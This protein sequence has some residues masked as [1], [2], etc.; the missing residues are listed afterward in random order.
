M[1]MYMQVLVHVH[2]YK[3]EKNYIHVLK[4]SFYTHS[5]NE[6]GKATESDHHGRKLTPSA[7]CCTVATT[8]TVLDFKQCFNI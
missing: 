7:Q 8:S 6:I 1:Y 3:T 2:M 4:N 5:Q